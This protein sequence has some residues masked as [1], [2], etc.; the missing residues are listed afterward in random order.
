MSGYF[1]LFSYLVIFLYKY[2]NKRK[3]TIRIVTKKNILLII[4]AFVLLIPIAL[5]Y[6]S[7]SKE[8]NYTRDIRDA[9]HFALQPEDFFYPNGH[10]RLEKTLLKF[11][12]PVYVKGLKEDQIL[13]AMG[14][15]KKTEGR[16][17]RFVLPVKLGK[18]IV[19]KDVPIPVIQEAL[20]RRK[21]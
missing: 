7:V 20:S 1:I 19:Q 2:I 3:E 13:K 18:V 12:L 8:F 10:T 21:N 11:S 6:Y 14:Y 17:N 16:K 4:F 15:D 9:I 5:P